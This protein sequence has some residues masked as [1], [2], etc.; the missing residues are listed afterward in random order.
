MPNRSQNT[1]SNLIQ[2]PTPAEIKAYRATSGEG[3]L[4]SRKILSKVA[5]KRA[6]VDNLDKITEI[7]NE[8]FI[9]TVERGISILL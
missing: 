9:Y 5:I 4:T 8:V 3:L 2:W 1:M 6:I 7:N